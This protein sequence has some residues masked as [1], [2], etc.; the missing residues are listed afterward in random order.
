MTV[1]PHDELIVPGARRLGRRLARNT[2][3]VL[4]EES[5]PRRVV[6]PAGGSWY[7]EHLTDQLAEAAWA[8]SRRSNG[9]AASSRRCEPGWSQE[10]VA[11]S[12]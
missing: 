11:A 2:Q 6:D 8:G 5:Q 12:A 9:P 10:H 4:I 1:L 3:L 7:V